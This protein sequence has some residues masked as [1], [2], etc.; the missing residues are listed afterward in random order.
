MIVFRF[1]ASGKLLA[2]DAGL[3]LTCGCR[4]VSF[5]LFLNALLQAR[6]GGGPS[7]LGPHSACQSQDPD[8]GGDCLNRN[9]CNL[10]TEDTANV[11]LVL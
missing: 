1:W 11:L 4:C 7:P 5:S 6:D 3:S 2:L 8:I 9:D 10:W